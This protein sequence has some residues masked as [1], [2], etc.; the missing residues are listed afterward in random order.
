MNYKPILFVC[1]ILSAQVLCAGNMADAVKQSRVKG[2]IVVHLGCGDGSET[3]DMLLGSSY[4]V[5]GL[6]TSGDNIAKAR[7][8]LHSKNLYGSVSVAQYDG[9]NLP[10]GDNIVN[11]VVASGECR[12]AR[13]EIARVLVPG[14]VAIRLDPETRNLKP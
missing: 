1:L 2:G 13:E 10:Y 8:N 5:H 6:D 12:V 4:L 3:A 7:A 11:L 9:K 14:G